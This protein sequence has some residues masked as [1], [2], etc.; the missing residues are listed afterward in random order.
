[1]FIRKL[2]IIH[3]LSIILLFERDNCICRAMVALPLS[4]YFYQ[5][6]NKCIPIIMTKNGVNST[7]HP[8]YPSNQ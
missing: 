3:P 6:R 4:L 7:S 1:M 8:C 5:A 2:K